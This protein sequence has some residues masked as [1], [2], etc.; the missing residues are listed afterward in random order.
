MDFKFLSGFLVGFLVSVPVSIISFIFT[1]FHF[2]KKV[3]NISDDNN[4]P[5]RIG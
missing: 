4:S 2:T 5:R 3:Q 1:W